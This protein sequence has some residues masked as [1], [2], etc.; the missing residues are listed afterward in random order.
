[1]YQCV[2]NVESQMMA[3]FLRY[4]F[5]P[6]EGSEVCRVS[7]SRPVGA[8][9][10]AYAQ[11][12]LM[13]CEVAGDHLV[14]LDIPWY[15]NAVSSLTN[16]YVYFSKE[17]AARINLALKA[18]FDLDFTGYYRKGEELGFRKM[19]IVDAYIFSRHL[20]P[21]SYDALHKREYRNAQRA[22]ERI[23][24][25]LLRKAYYVNESIDFTG[26]ISK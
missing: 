21:E 4:I 16:H 10:V 26:L 19:D 3:D 22:Q 8:L 5:P 2:L 25:R 11:P 7:A 17:A 20:A 23:K 15:R 14:K 6:G 18:E 1:M 13:P 24:Q 12:S 9:M